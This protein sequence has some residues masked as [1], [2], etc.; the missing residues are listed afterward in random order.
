MRHGSRIDPPNRFETH[1]RELDLEH[2]EW[3]QE[4]IRTID[5]RNIEYVSDES[6]SIVSEN[7]S[8]DV[9]FRFSLNPYRGCIHG[10]S[11]CYARP[12]HEFLG[13]NA[14]LDFETR[15]VVK[16]RA[17]ALFQEFLSKD[18]WTPEHI[19]FSGITDCYQPAERKFRLTRACLEVARECGQP[20]SVITKN[21]LV[22]RDL[23]IIQ[24]LAS[25]QLIHVFLSITTQDPELAREM[26]P[27]TSVPSARLRAVKMLADAGVPV[28]VM[29]APLIPG[30]NDSEVPQIMEAAKAAGAKS[31][32]YV[33]LR[34]PLTVEPVFI[35]WLQRTQPLKAERV[36]GRIRQT[37]DG[38]LNNA[39]FGERM[40]G[41][42]EI[43]EQIRSMFMMFRKKAGLDRKLPPYNRDLFH[44]PASPSGQ[45]MLF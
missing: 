3:D 8:P 6:K 24:E 39:T 35:E 15:I 26:E 40:V 4:Y 13:F 14:G 22:L 7:N 41:N 18:S 16:H 20:V 11:Y 44:P 33:L 5:N 34:L 25:N 21:A 32:G 9:P 23:D 2:L 30:L 1:Q 27:R 10:C 38:Q 28:G 45:Q 37:R 19:T 12:S 17:P 31:A 43:A 42:G 36:L 29:I